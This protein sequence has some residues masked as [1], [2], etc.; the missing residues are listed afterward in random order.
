[1]PP[2]VDVCQH[3]IWSP[4]IIWMYW[5]IT[6]LSTVGYENLHPVNSKMRVACIIYMFLNFGAV[7]YVIGN[8]TRIA[9]SS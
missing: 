1:M 8:I 5:S 2:E 6:S 7:P 4:Y 3:N 9:F